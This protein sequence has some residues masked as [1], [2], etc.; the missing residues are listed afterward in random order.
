MSP[1]RSGFDFRGIHYTSWWHDEYASPGAA[2]SRAAAA[3]LGANW[4]AVLATWYQPDATHGPI[5]TLANKTPTDDAVTQAIRD[6]QRLGLKV[7]LKPHIDGGQGEI[8]RGTIQP[9][10]AAAWFSSYT[11]FILH[12]A[13][14]ALSLSVDLF[15]IGDELKLITTARYEARW[16]AVI[17]DVRSVY[18]GPLTYAANAAS[19]NDEFSW[20]PFWGCARLHRP[21]L[22]LPLT[23]N[24]SPSLA[25]LV[26]AWRAPAAAIR[27]FQQRV[28]RPVVFTEIGYRS[29][30]G[31]EPGTLELQPAR[32]I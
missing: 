20:I 5:A 4:V 30:A 9:V 29:V 21:R 32:R 16:R 23:T 11:N 22:L 18:R 12:Y 14:L 13:A 7:M 10:D 26:A 31:R 2:Q 27:R 3:A 25:D 19:T 1:T 17:R 6:S 15:S 28:N 24:P 8:W